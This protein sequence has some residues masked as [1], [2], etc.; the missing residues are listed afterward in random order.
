M[1]SLPRDHAVRE[2]RA[3]GGAPTNCDVELPGVILE[4]EYQTI[5]PDF[6]DDGIPNVTWAQPG[7]AVP[8][9]NH[10]NTRGTSLQSLVTQILST[11]YQ[12]PPV[13]DTPHQI[14]FVAGQSP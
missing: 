11:P 10:N 2:V 8:Y 9:P 12:A 14:V 1:E 13:P 6:P 5:G 7:V 3:R 4:P